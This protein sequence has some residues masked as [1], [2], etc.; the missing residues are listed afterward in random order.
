MLSH[1]F[2]HNID[3]I[4]KKK[5]TERMCIHDIIIRIVCVHTYIHEIN[6]NYE[7]NNTNSLC[8]HTPMYT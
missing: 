2:A 3:H 4:Q 6:T 5:K 7:F 1:I 8:T